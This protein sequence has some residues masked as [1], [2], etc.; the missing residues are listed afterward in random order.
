MT[1]AWNLSVSRKQ[2]KKLVQ[3]TRMDPRERSRPNATPS[4]RRASHQQAKTNGKTL[5]GRK[6]EKY[7][8]LYVEHIMS[9]GYS[10][11]DIIEVVKAHGHLN[12]LRITS[13][14]VVHNRVCKDMVGCKITVPVSQV[15]TALE[16]DC[17]P[18]DVCCRRWQRKPANKRRTGEEETRNNGASRRATGQNGDTSDQRPRPQRPQGQRNGQR[19]TQ[20]EYRPQYED[21]RARNGLNARPRDFWKDYG[22]RAATTRE[23]PAFWDHDDEEAEMWK[24]IKDC[25][26]TD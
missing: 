11:E 10:D 5:R 9:H 14:Y 2:K 18:E 17:W 8:T 22:D 3:E 15:D 19:G 4:P 26:H 16:P 13:A 21:K 6:P 7:A 12:Q 23:A 20:E 1:V 24:Y 25:E